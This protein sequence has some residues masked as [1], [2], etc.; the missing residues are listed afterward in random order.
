M[1]LR[2]DYSGLM[3]AN[4]GPGQGLSDAELAALAARG[5]PLLTRL[6]AERQR[7]GLAFW[8][9]PAERGPAQ[10]V[11][12]VAAAARERFSDAVILGIGGSSLG[13]RAVVDALSVPGAPGQLFDGGRGLRLHF[14][15]NVDA[16][17][18]GALLDRL[19]LEKTLFNVITKSGGTV[20]TMAQ[21]LIVR[22]LLMRRFGPAG[23]RDRVVATTDPQ[24][25]LL[26]RIAH[27]DGLTT[28]AIPPAVGGRFSVLT[29][30]GLLPAALAGVSPMALLDGAAAAF[31][32]C[33]RPFA[34]NPAALLAATL[35]A[36][37]TAKAKPILIVWPYGDAL[38][39]FADWFLQ[40]WAESLGKAHATDGRLVHC[41]P[42]PV[43][44]VG[45]TDQH[46]QLQLYIEGPFDKTVLFLTVDRAR[47]EL[48]IPAGA[49][50]WDEAAY[51]CGHDLGAILR[52]EQDATEAALQA[53]GRP[54]AALRFPTLDAARLGQAF[55]LCEVATALAGAFYDV[56][57]FDQPGVEGGKQRAYA[58]LGRPGFAEVRQRFEAER[59]ARRPYV[60]AD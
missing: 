12:R 7:G 26:R 52:A 32:A 46:S 42:T 17:T 49:S 59:A 51:L 34:E 48:R 29:P 1:D 6:R 21:F 41:G 30:V 19:D 11:A 53:A 23:Y 16:E 27:D 40:L 55:L 37:D 50:P 36:A 9:L 5:E 3:A 35:Y 45:A 10:E 60:C 39:T 22:D 47:R 8:A 4:I 54:T 57:P 33:E 13:P 43:R 58:L 14:P 2:F 25:G 18:F 56:D 31:A 28:L 20:E 38:R 15:D 24:K 44:A